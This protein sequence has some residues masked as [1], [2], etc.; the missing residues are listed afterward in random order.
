MNTLTFETLETA[1]GMVAIWKEIEPMSMSFDIG[2]LARF[3]LSRDN[4]KKTVQEKVEEKAEDILLSG[5]KPATKEQ[6]AIL[7]IWLFQNLSWQNVRVSAHIKWIKSL[8]EY[9]NFLT[10]MKAIWIFSHTRFFT[11][12]N[13]RKWVW[14]LKYLY[15]NYKTKSSIEIA[16]RTKPN[17]PASDADLE[18]LRKL[19][20]VYPEITSI[21]TIQK[22]ANS[23]PNTS[24]WWQMTKE[25]EEVKQAEARRKLGLD[26]ESL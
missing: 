23:Q 1:I 10:I 11:W 14:S 20:L 15:W 13:D 16:M 2:E 6:E 5:I 25:Q 9:E 17:L 21:F 12:E 4:K 19:S 3:I 24:N 7:L 22:D 26:Y 18:I 8:L